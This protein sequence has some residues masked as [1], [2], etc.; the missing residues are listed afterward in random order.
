MSTAPA[1]TAVQNAANTSENRF[2]F[3]KNWQRFLKVLNDDRIMEAENSLRNMLQVE[4]L[5]G[6]SFLDIGSGSG[7]FSLAAMRLGAARVHSFDYDHHSVACTQELRRRYFQQA[8]NWTIEQ[9]SVLEADYLD[10]LEEFDVVYS[11]GVLHHTGDMWL[12]L[13]NA[14]RPVA[15]QGKLFIALYN[16]QDLYSSVW[17]AI[18]RRYSQSIFWRVPIIVV[19]GTFLSLRGLAKDLIL[20]K[21][22]LKRYT[23]YK[24][25]RG[26]SY[27]TDLLDWLGGYPFEVAKPEA[28]FDFFRNRGFEM[29]KLHTVGGGLGCNEFVFV[30]RTESAS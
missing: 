3:G 10:R 16:H 28:V 4:D 7:L 14:I 5:R 9:G 2:A 15:P 25:S 26:M 11:W 13:E 27:F 6:K 8:G 18:K 22:P 19:C 20:L 1:G 24:K 23:E 17:T 29:V 21:N 30:K 12:A